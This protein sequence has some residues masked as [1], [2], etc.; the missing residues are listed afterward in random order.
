MILGS[1]SP[2]YPI[3]KSIVTV[4]QADNFKAQLEEIKSYLYRKSINSARLLERTL[5]TPIFENLKD[6]CL[7][8]K[9]SLTNPATVEKLLD[10]LHEE[11]LNSLILRIEIAFEPTQ[12]T[13]DLISDW[14]GRHAAGPKILLSFSVDRELV[15]SA[16]IFFS[17][18]MWDYSLKSKLQT[19]KLSANG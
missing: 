9:Y 18:K 2:Y 10:G 7:R 13:V 12:K 11:V 17:G 3:L 8:N 19:L 16:R 4:D 1:V 14:L 15:A 6:Y 5:S